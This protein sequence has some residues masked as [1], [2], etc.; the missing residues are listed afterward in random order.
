M[1]TKKILAFSFLFTLFFS[2]CSSNFSSVSTPNVNPNLAPPKDIKFLTDTNTVGFE[3]AFSNDYNIKGYQIYRKKENEGKFSKI[4]TLDSRF[5]THFADNNLESNTTYQYKFNAFDKDK[6][7]SQDSEIITAKT[8]ALNPIDYFKALS[9]YPRKVKLIW[10]PHSDT[11]VIGYLIE[12]K[13]KNGEWKKL[14]EVNSRLLV[15]Y[16]DKNLE[17]AMT[18]E[19]RIFAYNKHKSL[20]LPSEASS[21]TTKPK[22]QAITTL[23]ATSNLPKSIHLQ[24]EAHNNPEVIQY[25]IYRSTF[26]DSFFTELVALPSH[27]TQYQDAIKDDGKEYHYK[28]AAI[29]KDGIQSLDSPIVTG[30]TLPIPATPIITYAQIEGNSIVIR[31][32]PAD[33]RAKEY[34]VYKKDFRFF[35]ETL[36]YTRVLTPEFIDREIIGGGKYY[37][38]VSALDENGIESQKTQEV[39]LQLPNQ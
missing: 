38:S 10:N 19:Y 36:R 35:G 16:I 32:N 33:N 8:L 31:W 27:T 7:L 11:R 21:A 12:K 15:E 14:S 1:L 5:T 23:S 28:I 4:A 2:A 18:Y 37:Y 13:D 24:W 25:K 17:D 9:N 29:D 26:L 34:V 3:W 20:S 6:T 30:K 39:I 22:P